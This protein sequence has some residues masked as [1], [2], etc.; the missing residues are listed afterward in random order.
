MDVSRPAIPDRRFAMTTPTIAAPALRSDPTNRH[1][2]MRSCLAANVVAAGIPGLAPV[3]APDLAESVAGGPADPVVAR[4]IGAVWLGIG[5]VSLLSWR[6]PQQARGV[7]GVQVIYKSTWVL[8]AGVPAI[9][10][11]TASATTAGLT[12]GFLMMIATW[13]AV[14]WRSRQR[15]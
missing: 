12:G 2:A 7:L 10:A 13:S 1:V 15:A 6:R 3:A 4:L 14:L 9:V 11:G 8:T 5:V